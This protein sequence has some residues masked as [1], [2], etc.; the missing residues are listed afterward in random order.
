MVVAR[1]LAVGAQQ[2]H[3]LG[4]L[5]A[6]GDHRAAVAPRTEVL[7]GVEAEAA[8]GPVRADALAAVARAVRLA[9]VLQHLD[10]RFARQCENRVEIDGGPEQVHG[11]H[12]ARAR[13]EGLA[14]SSAVIRCESGSTSI[15][16]GTAPTALTASA[17]AMKELVGT[18]TSSPLPISSAR[19]ASAS[20]SVPEET[21]IAKS[22]SQ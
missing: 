21:P 13:G 16:T 15:G 6:G 1:A 7:G 8:E 12:A 5:R 4:Q 3:A 20:A 17:V 2:P 11:D 10:A 9:G 22:L 14:T 19:S 18:I